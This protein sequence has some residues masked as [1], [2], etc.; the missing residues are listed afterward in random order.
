MISDSWS[1]C[2][3]TIL[4]VQLW[5]WCDLW[6]LPLGNSFLICP[7]YWKLELCVNKLLSL[8]MASS[9]A[10]NTFVFIFSEQFPLGYKVSWKDISLIIWPKRSPMVPDW[11]L[12][13][14]FGDRAW[15][16]VNCGRNWGGTWTKRW[17]DCSTNDAWHVSDN[18]N[19][20]LWQAV[21]SSALLWKPFLI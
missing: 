18:I 3:A 10:K 6:R 16:N 17:G 15:G 13:F 11:P 19:N 7:V 20:N 14:L 12:R 21:D 5:G 1:W 4:G 9:A 8:F 2:P